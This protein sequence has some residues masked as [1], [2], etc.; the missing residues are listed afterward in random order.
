MALLTT[1][2]AITLADTDASVR[3]AVDAALLAFGVSEGDLDSPT[4][5]R[6]D[7]V[8]VVALLDYYISDY[9]TGPAAALFDART[10]DGSD[11]KES[12][13]FAHLVKFRDVAKKRIQELGYVAGD[14]V[15]GNLA[16]S[17]L[18]PEASGL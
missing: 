10:A 3:P 17:F 14:F 15:I 13:V 1:Q 5:G 9:L 7:A 4:I 8:D 11:L 6:A 2:L 18:E 12:Q 16:L